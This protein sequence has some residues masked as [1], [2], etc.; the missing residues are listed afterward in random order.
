MNFNYSIYQRCEGCYRSTSARPV[1]SAKFSFIFPT[2]QIK[3]QNYFIPFEIYFR[4][5][6]I[7]K[8]GLKEFES[9]TVCTANDVWTNAAAICNLQMLLFNIMMRIGELSNN[10]IWK[11][12]TYWNSTFKKI[13]HTKHQLIHFEVMILTLKFTNQYNVELLLD[14]CKILANVWMFETD[15]IFF[16]CICE[17]TGVHFVIN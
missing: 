1:L 15:G 7:T 11:W 9:K 5:V 2:F 4:C 17:I 6:S 13:F 10:S 3:T 12:Y 16:K 8:C 14:L